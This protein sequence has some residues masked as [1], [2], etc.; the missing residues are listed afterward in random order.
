MEVAEFSPL[1]TVDFLEEA[2]DS[3]TPMTFLSPMSSDSVRSPYSERLEKVKFFHEDKNRM[4]LEKRERDVN[5]LE[6]KVMRGKEFQQQ[7][8]AKAQESMRAWHKKNMQSSMRRDTMA[9]RNDGEFYEKMESRKILMGD[10][11]ARADQEREEY[12]GSRRQVQ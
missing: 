3:T 6:E 9:S 1:D 5:K 2:I 7:K 4:A 11:K 12:F 8:A 10:K